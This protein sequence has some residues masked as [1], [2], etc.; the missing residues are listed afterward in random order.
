MAED[1]PPKTAGD[2]DAEVDTDTRGACRGAGDGTGE[3]TELD[4]EIVPEKGVPDGVPTVISWG[5]FPLM[6]EDRDKRLFSNRRNELSGMTDLSMIFGE[7]P[8]LTAPFSLLFTI[9][10]SLDWDALIGDAVCEGIEVGAGMAI[11]A[12]TFALVCDSISTLGETG[13]LVV[14]GI[15]LPNLST[16]PFDS[17]DG[18]ATG[19]DWRPVCTSDAVGYLV[20][21]V[22]ET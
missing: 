17:D 4:V 8:L 9:H 21:P 6:L 10:V 11:S 3:A 16:K 20:P 14:C 13:C 1:D 7:G 18:V 2:A 22:W 19:V 5:T 12:L 15:S